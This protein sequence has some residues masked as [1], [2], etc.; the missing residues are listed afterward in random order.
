MSEQDSVALVRLILLRVAVSTKRRMKAVS[1]SGD[2]HGWRDPGDIAEMLD[3]L[4]MPVCDLRDA[5]VS[6]RQERVE[7]YRR[8]SCSS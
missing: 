2:L 1:R 4:R 5:P 6:T 7:W 8:W 3:S